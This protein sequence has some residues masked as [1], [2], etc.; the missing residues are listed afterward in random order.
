MSSSNVGDDPKPLLIKKISHIP[1]I[2]LRNN[3]VT[4]LKSENSEILKNIKTIS[5]LQNLYKDDLIYESKQGDFLKSTDYSVTITSHHNLSTNSVRTTAKY[6]SHNGN[7]SYVKSSDNVVKLIGQDN[8]N[9]LFGTLCSVLNLEFKVRGILALQTV[10]KT[11]QEVGCQTDSASESDRKVSCTVSTL[12]QTDET[13]MDILL[14]PKK[15]KRVKRLHQTPYV[16]KDEPKVVEDMNGMEYKMVKKIVIK[17]ENFDK[18]HLNEK[19]SVDN[20]ILSNEKQTLPMIGHLALDEDSNASTGNLSSFSVNTLPQL[21]DDPFSLLNIEKFTEIESGTKN[22]SRN[23]IINPVLITL[24]DNTKIEIPIKP[25]DQFHIATPDILKLLSPEHRRKL[26]F[27]QAYIDW[28]HCLD[29]DEDGYMPLHLAVQNGD[30]D[31]VRRQCLALKMRQESVDVTAENMTA[32]QLSLYRPFPECTAMLLRFGADPL[33]ADSEDRTCIHLAA[34]EKSDHLR[35]IINYCQSNPMRIINENEEFWRPELENK[36]KEELVQ[37]LFNKL[38]RMND[39]QGYTPLMLASKTGNYEAVKA[40]VEMAP[41]SVNLQMPNSGDTAL[42]LAVGAACMD[43]SNRGNMMKVADNYVKT[44]EILIEN[45]AD[46]SIDNHSGN[47]VNVL[48]TEFNIGELSLLIANKLTAINC[49]NGA[50]PKSKG[51]DV[52]MLIKDKDGKVNVKEVPR[53]NKDKRKDT[54]PTI[55]DNTRVDTKIY[56]SANKI[57]MIIKKNTEGTE[58][59]DGNVTSKQDTEQTNSDT[60]FMNTF[61]NFIKNN[62]NVDT[63]N[64]P[65][66]VER[67]PI[68]SSNKEITG[69]STSAR[70]PPSQEIASKRNASQNILNMPIVSPKREK[71]SNNLIIEIL[72]NQK[73]S[74]TNINTTQNTETVVKRLVKPLKRNAKF[75]IEPIASTSTSAQVTGVT[76]QSAPNQVAILKSHVPTSENDTKRLKLTIEK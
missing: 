6:V 16:V 60:N 46:P 28:K 21:M 72:S 49:F 11:S 19:S 47:N 44:I 35:A 37:Y 4:V 62:N 45:G 34:E 57:N 20:S 17:P 30:V 1:H 10:S 27:L 23:M 14:K 69:S 66:M 2:F 42:Y 5:P 29:R 58:R 18:F 24:L 51:S 48:L 67:R 56:H 68:V 33:I 71:K 64:I 15:R 50:I 54:K 59:R 75:I 61:K 13:S 3:K 26:L 52:F 7:D 36:A 70:V 32:L 12:S 43:A 40:L 31:L 38:S 41:S 39:N 63:A 9:V 8:Y 55:L 73:Q 74:N 53:D 65:I 76:G 25:E 22:E